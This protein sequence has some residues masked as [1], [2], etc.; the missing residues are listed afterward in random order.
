MKKN[1]DFWSILHT[2]I[3]RCNWWPF[4][5][6]YNSQSKLCL[7]DQSL[8]LTKM[9]IKMV[10]FTGIFI[11][12][13][14]VVVRKLLEQTYNYHFLRDLYNTPAANMNMIDYSIIK[15]Y[16]LNIVVLKCWQ[17]TSQHLL[18]YV[19]LFFWINIQNLQICM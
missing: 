14:M 10:D 1:Q 16:S 19:I 6:Y 7:S 4:T 12:T 3:V 11:Y 17:N 5:I 15:K 8:I 2:N 9:W 18:C 13:Y